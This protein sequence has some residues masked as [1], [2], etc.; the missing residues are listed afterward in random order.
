[1]RTF[2]TVVQCAELVRSVTVF[3]LWACAL[4]ADI[5][6]Y[7]QQVHCSK[8]CQESHVD[9][10]WVSTGW[11]G[12]TRERQASGLF[13]LSGCRCTREGHCHLL[14][15]YHEPSA[16]FRELASRRFYI[17][18][19]CVKESQH[20]PNRYRA[21]L[22]CAIAQDC[23]EVATRY[24][25]RRSG[26]YY[27]GAWGGRLGSIDDGLLD[28]RSSWLLPWSHGTFHHTSVKVGIE[29]CK[30][31][32][33]L[34]VTQVCLNTHTLCTHTCSTLSNIVVC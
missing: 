13:S 23:H 7:R 9:S 15:Q 20:R 34:K 30:P 24:A 33:W 26:A 6:G 16:A 3:S 11:P 32:R 8:G 28:V 18:F 12:R 25:G 21:G 2:W 22:H 10:F 1:M 29:S 14:W 17:N 5:D 19:V 4:S 27:P 31:E